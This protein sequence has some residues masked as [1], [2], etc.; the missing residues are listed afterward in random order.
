MWGATCGLVLAIWNW[1][2][3]STL[4]VWGATRIIRHY[5]L[6]GVYFNPRSPC[7]E[8]LIALPVLGCVEQFQSTLP[9]WG[10]T[11][12]GQH[13]R[14]TTGI[15]IHAPRVGSDQPGR[16]TPSTIFVFQSTLPVWGATKDGVKV[17]QVQRI[18]IH[19]P[20]V[21]S[22]P[23]SGQER[24]VES[25]FNPR[26]PCGERRRTQSQCPGDRY[27]NPRSPCGE[28]QLD[29]AGVEYGWGSQST[30]PV[31]GAT[32]GPQFRRSARQDFNPRSPC[33]ERPGCPGQFPGLTDISIH[34]P[35]VGSDAG[36]PRGGPVER[37]FNPR[38]PCGERPLP[39]WGGPPPVIFQSTLPVWGAT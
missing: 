30:L 37:H 1:R 38:S 2:F 3:Q 10:A 18:S 35:R 27:F 8:R 31:W 20:R 4:P 36:L 17:I 5:I 13:Q 26:S 9:V 12:C 21:G 33:G 22:D 6:P 15:S 7:G 14:D 29:I 34:A 24:L 28:R 16:S 32:P 11:Q 19:A 23:G 25:D 39:I